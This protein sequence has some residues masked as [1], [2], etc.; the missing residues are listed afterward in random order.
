MNCSACIVGGFAGA[1]TLTVTHEVLRH[2]FDEAPR[3]DIIGARAVKRALRAAHLP[4]PSGQA[5]LES[6][7][8]ADLVVNSAA[9]ALAG[10]GKHACLKGA[11]LGLALGIGSVT[12][13]E[14]LGLGK[15]PVATPKSKSL[16]IALYTLAGLV[17]GAVAHHVARHD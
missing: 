9:F 6:T 1:L 5:L 13:P 17:A 2:N 16:S 15:P 4:T 8:A 3:L 14:P 10:S 12:L 11:V 7:L